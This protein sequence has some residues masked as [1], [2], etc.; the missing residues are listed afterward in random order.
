MTRFFSG[1]APEDDGQESEEDDSLSESDET[2]PRVPDK[3]EFPVPQGPSEESVAEQQ[4]SDPTISKVI[5]WVK[6]KHKPS[7]QEY[8]LLTSDEKFYADCFESL[9]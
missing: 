8:K 4:S 2:D 3:T 5:S 6:H 1:E 7:S 9:R